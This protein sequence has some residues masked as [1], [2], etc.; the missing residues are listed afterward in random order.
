MASDTVQLQCGQCKNV[1]AISVAHLGQ[2][3]QCPHCKA[4]LQ[5]PAPS[6]PP[7]PPPEAITST[8]PTVAPDPVPQTPTAE[9]D[10]GANPGIVLTPSTV[11]AETD[12]AQFK[13]KPRKDRTVFLIIAL[14]FLVPYAITM[15]IF[16]LL[17]AMIQRSD[18]LEYLPDPA[19]TKGGPKKVSRAQP[20]PE[21][22][23]AAH[24]KTTLGNPVKAG[25]LLVTPQKIVL[26]HS[27]DL[28]LIL[29][30][31]NTSTTTT[32]EPMHESFVNPKQVKPYTFLESRSGGR[33][34]VTNHYL[35][36]HK[37]SRADD[38]PTGE[39]MLGPN[40][41]TVIALTTTE[42]FRDKW[43]TPIAKS[44]G[45]QFTW[46]VQVRRGFVEVN[47]RPVSAT[48]VIGVDF[49]SKDIEREG[50]S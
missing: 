24:R 8:A 46:R 28:K 1:L 35:G 34:G 45:E 41:E 37:N 44:S 50:K 6:A 47:R 27:G 7:A 25:D 42:K 30:A 40:E 2:Q 31:K 18:P 11:D 39:A 16:V 29:R 32:F 13:P 20:V 36:Y 21:T 23:I 9:H 4:V 33:S 38:E 14:I 15:T 26:T 17:M 22:P 3:V 19:P 12:F 10:V 48:T 49:S 43:V 5:T